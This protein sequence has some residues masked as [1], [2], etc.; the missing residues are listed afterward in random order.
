M[1][2]N[3]TGDSWDTLRGIVRDAG[4]AGAGAGAEP[5]KKPNGAAH[6]DAGDD[7][8]E[9]DAGDEIME[10]T[11]DWKEWKKYAKERQKRE[12]QYRTERNRFRGELAAERQAREAEK[13]RLEDEVTAIR[14]LSKTEMENALKD[15]TSAADKRVINVEI[16]HALVAAGCKDPAD[17]LKI[18]DASGIKISEAG[19]VTGVAEVITELKKSKPY[20][21]DGAS[22]SNSSSRS[23]PP[24]RDD[25]GQKNAKD[26]TAEEYAAARAAYTKTRTPR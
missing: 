4:G 7:N 15:A 3:M 11:Q 26:M 18:V 9:E 8:D 25:T 17:V 20:L 2:I 10:P 5:P 24:N 12:A 14:G 1:K 21:F 16:R 13:K 22:S 19:E 23:A 6:A